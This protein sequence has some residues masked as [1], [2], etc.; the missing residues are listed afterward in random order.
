MTMTGAEAD[1]RFLRRIL[2]LLVAATLG[3]G[4]LT[5][6]QTVKAAPEWQTVPIQN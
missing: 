5:G 2:I 4:L 6:V 3:A 1:A